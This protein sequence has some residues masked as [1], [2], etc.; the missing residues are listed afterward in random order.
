M[1]AVEQLARDRIDHT[2]AVRRL[3]RGRAFRLHA[4]RHPGRSAQGDENPLSIRRG[5]DSAR[6]LA[7]WKCRDNGISRSI[8]HR[9]IA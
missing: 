7:D 1:P 8:D 5:V 9:Y 4:R 6:P 3:V 2:E